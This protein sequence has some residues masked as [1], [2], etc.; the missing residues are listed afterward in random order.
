M[1][2]DHFTRRKFLVSTAAGTVGTMLAGQISALGVTNVPSLSRPAIQGGDPVRT[3]GWMRWPVWNRDA[4]DP[5]LAVLRSGNWWSG[6]GSRCNEFEGA[7][8]ALIG[9]RRAVATASGTTALMTALHVLGVDAGD[10]VIV[11]PYTFIATYNV[12]FNQKALPVFADTDQETFTIN[13]LKIEERITERTRAILPVHILGLPADMNRINSIAKKHDL[14]VI[15]DACQ[16]W[17]A[18][19]GGKMCGTLGDLGC[20]SFQNSKHI[21]AGEGGAVVGNDDRLMDLCFSY[22]NCGRPHGDSMS[23]MKGYPIRGSNKRMTE[24]QAVILLSQMQRARS[25]ADK[26][27]ENALY[28][29]ANLRE[30]PGIIPYKLADGATRS[31]YH[32]YPFRY[33]K[34]FFDGL[35]RQK[36]LD[37]LEAEGIPCMEGYGRQYFDGLIEEAISSRGYKRLYSEQRLNLYREELHQLPDNDQLTQEAVWFSQNMLLA[38]REDMDDIIRAVQ[39]VYEHRKEL[40]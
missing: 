28:L 5:M 37:A 7:Y 32:L 8:A 1:K 9:A 6:S 4:E 35:S 40:I 38:E 39:K 33:K 16:A 34:E 18:E 10:E 11:S 14:A 27:L 12:V 29:D 15:E 25:D 30:I 20:F 31:A 26:R 2:R 19:Y 3:K 17:L 13:P 36:F 21:P 22:H 24:L 23:A